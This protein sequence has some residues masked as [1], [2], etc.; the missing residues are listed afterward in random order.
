M[1]SS[2]SIPNTTVDEVV[3]VDIASPVADGGSARADLAFVRNMLSTAAA[4]RTLTAAIQTLPHSIPLTSAICG[5]KDLDSISPGGKTISALAASVMELALLVVGEYNTVID[6]LGGRSWLWNHARD[7]WSITK[8]LA[9]ATDEMIHA[10][11]KLAEMVREGI[12]KKTED[13]VLC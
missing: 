5:N 12:E 8:D 13:V 6:I 4:M 9:D 7:L 2:I 10:A 1:P 11:K 3:R